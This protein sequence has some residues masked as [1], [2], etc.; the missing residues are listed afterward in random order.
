MQ[1]TPQKRG[2]QQTWETLT[3]QFSTK[4]TAKAEYWSPEFSESKEIASEF[5]LLDDTCKCDMILGHEKSQALKMVID[6]NR[7]VASWD[8][9]E[10]DVKN[11]AELDSHE[12][13][14]ETFWKHTKPTSVHAANK[15]AMRMQHAMHKKANT[16]KV[17]HKNCTHLSAEEKVC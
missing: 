3:G 9:I 1:N 13:M 14:C 17:M 2:T 4:E 10:T 16:C 6:F 7:N 5:H 12:H 8:G 15:C 11:S